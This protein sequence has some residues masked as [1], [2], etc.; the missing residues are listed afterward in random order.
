MVG[1]ASK[2]RRIL[3]ATAEIIRHGVTGAVVGDTSP[4]A[5]AA[6]IDE[7]VTATPVEYDKMSKACRSD[8]LDRFSWRSFVEETLRFQ[9][10][11][12]S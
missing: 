3:T 6:A 9:E 8:V 12:I 5:L 2:G 4:K 7:I 11:C 1:F 10:S